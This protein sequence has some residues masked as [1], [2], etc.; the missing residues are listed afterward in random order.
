VPLGHYGPQRGKPPYPAY[1]ACF[2]SPED[3]AIHYCGFT[4]IGRVDIE[5]LETPGFP[6][7]TRFDASRPEARRPGIIV[8]KG[9]VLFWQTDEDGYVEELHGWYPLEHQGPHLMKLH[10]AAQLIETAKCL[11]G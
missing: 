1:R 6:M 5:R 2:W 7:V 9:C 11:S 10:T 4:L 3:G 8:H